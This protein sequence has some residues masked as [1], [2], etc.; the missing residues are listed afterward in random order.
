MVR[1]SVVPPAPRAGAHPAAASA[2]TAQPSAPK[3][4]ARRGPPAPLPLPRPSDD[5]V[6]HI[7]PFPLAVFAHQVGEGRPVDDVGDRLADPAPEPEEVAFAVEVALLVARLA[8]AVDRGDRA[9]DVAHDLADR[10]LV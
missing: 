2:T 3:A 9:V 7:A 4:Q 8:D 5:P 6:A 1:V 10:Q